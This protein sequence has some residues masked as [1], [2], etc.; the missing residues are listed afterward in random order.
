MVDAEQQLQ[1]PQVFL[2]AMITEI[3]LW[4]YFAQLLQSAFLSTHP[5]KKSRKE[6]HNRHKN[7]SKNIL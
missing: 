7:H 1:T 2:Q 6:H 3:V 4:Q 5:S